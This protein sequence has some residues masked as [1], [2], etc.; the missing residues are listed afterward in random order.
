MPRNVLQ[1]KNAYIEEEASQ[2]R[3]DHDGRRQ[4]NR[5]IGWVLILV[6]ILFILPIFNLANTRQVLE[7]R[8]K[9][10]REMDQQYQQLEKEE[11]R[12]ATLAKKLEDDDYASKYMRARYYYSKDGETIYTIPD[13]LPK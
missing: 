1:M 5:F 7:Q 9:Q 4:R 8:Q 6:V 13:L 10:Y 12:L 11:E 3:N 2:R